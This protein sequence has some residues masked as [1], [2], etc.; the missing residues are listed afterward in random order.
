MHGHADRDGLHRQHGVRH[1]RAEVGFRQHDDRRGAALPGTGDVTLESSQ[2]EVVVEP[3]EQES[4]V[5]VRRQHLFGRVLACGLADERAS[6]LED[7]RDRRRR[8][9]SHPIADSGELSADL[10]VV[11]HSAGRSRAQLALLREEDVF[12]AVLRGDAGR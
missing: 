3:C 7:R 12:T 8:S 4:G 10:V 6:P 5:D 1:V 2:A 11:E 9:H